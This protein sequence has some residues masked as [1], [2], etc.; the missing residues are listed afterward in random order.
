VFGDPSTGAYNDIEQATDLARAMVM[1]YGMSDRLG[2]MR[3]GTPQGQVFLGRDYNRGIDYSDE[4][5]ALIDEE[6]RKLITQAHEEA[7][8][9]LTTHRAALDRLVD[10]LLEKETLYQVDIEQLLDDVPKWQH[11]ADGTMRIHPP[12]IAKRGTGV[13]AVIASSD[14][15]AP[16]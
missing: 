4:V 12:R 11:A 6:V 5:A 14:E 15:G 3:Y 10:A 1:E 16:S 2:P 7:R 9:I 8:E 13:A